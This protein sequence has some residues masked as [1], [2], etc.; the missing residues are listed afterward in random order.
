MRPIDFDTDSDTDPDPDEGR[1]PA[2]GAEGAEGAEEGWSSGDRVADLWPLDDL[3]LG[4]IPTSISGRRTRPIDTD[5]DTDPDPDEGRTPAEGAEGAEEGWSSGDRVADVWPLDDLRL[6]RIPTSISGRRT[7]PIDTDSDTDPDPDEGRTPAEGAE[8][9][10]EGWGSGD[11]VADL[12]P[13]DDRRLGRVSTSIPG[14]RTRPIDT[15]FDFDFDFGLHGT[16]TMGG[17]A[18]RQPVTRAKRSGS[19]LRPPTSDLARG[20]EAHAPRH[21]PSCRESVPRIRFGL[22]H[23]AHFPYERMLTTSRRLGVCGWS[24]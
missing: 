18:Q 4:R 11:R 2:E 10:E 24:G 15:D 6:G 14:R 9:A 1:T 5:S 21:A 12:W 13:L 7:R 8:G 20:S 3:R 16:P 22:I 17:L 23:R 19:D